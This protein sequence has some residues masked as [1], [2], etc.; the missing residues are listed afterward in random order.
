MNKE[1]IDIQYQNRFF[2]DSF[3]HFFSGCPESQLRRNTT[4]QEVQ[5]SKI[6]LF[7]TTSYL[8]S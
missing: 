2:P 8:G 5:F 7:L 3:V 6:Q 1:E 4:A